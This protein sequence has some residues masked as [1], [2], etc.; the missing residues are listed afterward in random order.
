VFIGGGPVGIEF[1]QML[2][3]F[4]SEVAIV[5]NH[6]S[7]LKREDPAVSKLIGKELESSS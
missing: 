5:H 7:L 6:E 1:G 4:G 3:R 2:A